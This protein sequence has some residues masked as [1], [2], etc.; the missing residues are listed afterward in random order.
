MNPSLSV[1]MPPLGWRARLGA[2]TTEHRRDG[3]LVA[4]FVASR[5]LMVVAA[6]VVEALITHNPLVEPAADGPILRSMFGGYRVP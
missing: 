2:V 3:G 5:L 4:L 1:P 6:F